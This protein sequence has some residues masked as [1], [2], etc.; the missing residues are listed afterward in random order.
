MAERRRELKR[1]VESLATL[2]FVP[3]DRP[4]M[5]AKAQAR[6]ADTVLVDLE[7]AIPP[8]GK[9]A[10]RAALREALRDG[11]LAGPGAVC[12][13]VNAVGE[14]V[15]QDLEALAGC[16][17]DAVVLPKAVGADGVREVRAGVDRLLDGGAATALVPQVESTAGILR[18]GELAAA[19][20]VDALAFGGEDFCVDLGVARSDDSLELLAP[21]ALVALH[22]RAARLPAIDTVYT[23][24]DDEDGLLREARV[25][26][27]LGF[28]GKLLI[29]PAQID[30]VRGVFAPSAEQVA[31][32]ERVRAAVAAAD[33]SGVQVVDGK[34]VDAPVLAQAER[35]LA[36]GRAR[37]NAVAPDGARAAASAASATGR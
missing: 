34:M 4:A 3:A 22:A 1:D 29:H 5:L 37:E 11:T 6:G 18:L 21:R 23:A 20:E 14:G 32:A 30:P 27:Q 19:P 31:W 13:R 8:D 16:A 35:I 25:A 24:I 26:R 10:A 36:R 15:E 28:S 12:V 2:L 9:G 33:G 7:D 17:V